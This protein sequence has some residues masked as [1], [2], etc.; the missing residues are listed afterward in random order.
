MISRMPTYPWQMHL[1]AALLG[2]QAATGRM[3]EDHEVAFVVS[4]SPEEA[5]QLA[6]GKWSGA[7]KGHVDAVQRIDVIDGCSVTVTPAS[8]AAGDHIE[9]HSYN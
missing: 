1:Y 3:G 9:L 2:G 4:G 7:G 5:R 8:D 6:K